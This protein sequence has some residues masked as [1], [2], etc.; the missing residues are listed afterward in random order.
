MIEPLIFKTS[1]A[2]LAQRRQLLKEIRIGAVLALA[3]GC[4]AANSLAAYEKFPI[5]AACALG[6]IALARLDTEG[7]L[8]AYRDRELR[9]QDQALEIVRGRFTRLL[10]F[11]HLEQLRMVQGRDEKV[12]A[13]QL[14]TL[15][16]AVLL[17][18]YENMESLFTALTARKPARVLLEVEESRMDW[19]SL[20]IWSR[21]VF[22]AGA[23]LLGFLYLK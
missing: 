18:G 9:V 12:L 21:M 1:Q 13:L 14:R 11:H 23:L 5:W 7:M 8:A 19:H 4:L 20:T 22:A 16:G 6:A 2:A 17:R 3:M 15:E 10:F